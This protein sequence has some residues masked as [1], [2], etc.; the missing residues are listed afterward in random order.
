MPSKKIV[1][2]PRQFL[3]PSSCPSQ[4]CSVQQ[5]ILKNGIISRESPPQ[6]TASH[7]YNNPS[8]TQVASRGT[9]RIFGHGEMADLIRAHDWTTTPLGPIEQWPDTLITTVN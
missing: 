1:A 7:A 5:L 2:A 6:M 3:H 4:S 8:M 9:Q